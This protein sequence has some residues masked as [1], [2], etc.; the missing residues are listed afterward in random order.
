MNL[1]LWGNRVFLR[2]KTLYV[3]ALGLCLSR[4]PTRSK[5]KFDLD[6]Q[7]HNSTPSTMTPQILARATY[8][9]NEAIAIMSNSGPQGFHEATE[10]LTDALHLIRE[11]LQAKEG[12]GAH[13][14]NPNTR[15]Q[16]DAFSF[17]CFY[18]KDKGVSTEMITDAR[19]DQDQGQFYFDRTIYI[20]P[21]ASPSLPEQ[22]CVTMLSFVLLYN[23]A[24]AHNI[25][26]L[27]DDQSIFNF[28]KAQILYEL[29]YTHAKERLHLS[30]QL[31]MAI[32][33]NLGQVHVSLRNFE[34]AR[35]CFETLISTI[36][37]SRIS[38]Q[39]MELELEGFLRTV[40]PLILQSNSARAA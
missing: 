26:A 7:K 15:A 6:P 3:F 8:L 19:D 20:N 4:M 1:P 10:L 5:Q 40:S 34:L 13:P 18:K 33:N 23:L 16:Q 2:D 32:A 11:L 39:E 12:G 22:L 25:Q 38:G 37:F 29:A 24:L 21:R 9:N 28:T 30:V 35:Q 14:I 27:Q 17:F 31:I 36:M